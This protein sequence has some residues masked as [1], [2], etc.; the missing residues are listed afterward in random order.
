[1]ISDKLNTFAE[2]T[3]VAHA[4]GTFVLGDVIDL[5]TA[6]PDLGNGEPIF[7][8]GIVK[9]D[10]EAAGA[11][12]LAFK[13]TSA[14]DDALTS[15]PVDH[16]IGPTLTTAAAA[17]AGQKAGDILF[18]FRLPSG[19]YKQFLGIRATV[20]TQAISDGKVDIFMTHDISAWKA[21]PSA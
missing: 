6:K 19:E 12:T 18:A 11:G 13:L 4:A 10:I 5:G 1:M 17:P 7:V 21:Y 9:D 3:A 14:A 2:D 15:G 16:Y 20:A 8:V